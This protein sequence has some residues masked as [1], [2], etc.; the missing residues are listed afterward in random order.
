M[1]GERMKQGSWVIVLGLALVGCSD[2][3]PEVSE[4][5]SGSDSGSGTTTDS[6]VTNP[7]SPTGPTGVPTSTS[8]TGMTTDVEPTT[9]SVDDTSGTTTDAPGTT[10]EGSSSS[11]G[12]PPE[13]MIDDDC[14]PGESCIDG[15][16][17]EQ[18]G[19][20]WGMGD[21]GGCLDGLGGFDADGLCGAPGSAICAAF[22]WPI[23][24][25]SCSV[26]NCATECDCP[27]PP[28]SGDAVV[29]CGS[30]PGTDGAPDCYLSCENGETCPDGMACFD[31]TVCMT[32][33]VDVPMYGNCGNLASDCLP[34]LE[35]VT[36]NGVT[37]CVSLCPGGIGDCDP[38]PPGANPEQC[39]GV[40][41]PPNG[42]DC[43][44][45]CI[46][47]GDCPGDMV[48]YD[49]P[50]VGGGASLCMWPYVVPPLPGG[51]CCGPN[52]GMPGCEVP[53]IEM[54]TCALDPFCC[55]TEWDMICVDV[56]SMSCNM[57]CI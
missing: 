31:N 47:D 8:D 10:S 41:F 12:V 55:N 39:G 57:I 13:C 51:N 46:N 7:T 4:S 1:S 52:P 9:G 38:A 44:L 49:D 27:A 40:I 29:T 23:E 45:P 3:A 20:M 43:H 21:W 15:M 48:C 22:A 42:P 25:T 32:E 36:E 30:L 17:T 14:D 34:G 53:A 50:S 26:Q 28:M 6:T 35:C 16:C 5:D 54:C 56:A 2:P 18:C 37:G 24:G 11:S 33:V 19:G